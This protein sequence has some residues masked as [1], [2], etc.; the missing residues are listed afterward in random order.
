MVQC[1]PQVFAFFGLSL[2]LRASV[3]KQFQFGIARKERRSDHVAGAFV[4]LMRLDYA[5]A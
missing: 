5:V 2:C 1:G 4:Q 3:V